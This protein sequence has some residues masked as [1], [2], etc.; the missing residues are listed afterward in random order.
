MFSDAST[1]FIPAVTQAPFVG[2]DQIA[3]P[4]TQPTLSLTSQQMQELQL[5]LMTLLQQQNVKLN[6]L[7]PDQQQLVISSL[8]NQQFQLSQS[9][10]NNV[11][12]GVA[13]AGN[14]P[15]Q[16]S[17]VPAGNN[18]STVVQYSPVA[19]TPVSLTAPQPVTVG[20]NSAIVENITTI[21]Q[22]MK[23]ERDRERGR[24]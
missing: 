22:V 21:D 11:S 16:F 2:V 15:V 20:S 3:P 19:S 23:R 18:N 8:I 7:T 4:T 17:V 5:Q 13:G 10:G 14:I 24:E 6:H 1:T 12:T 9:G